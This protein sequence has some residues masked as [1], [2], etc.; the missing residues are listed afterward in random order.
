MWGTL[1]P[2]YLAV[3]VVAALRGWRP[4]L[5][6]LALGG[7]GGF[8]LFIYWPGRFHGHEVRSFVQ[9][10]FYLFIG[11]TIAALAEWGRRQRDDALRRFEEHD[12]RLKLFDLASVLMLDLDHRILRWTAGCQRLYGYT[13]EQAIGRVTP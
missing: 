7:L 1:F 8:V 5:L 11:G 2:F 4:G 12:A 10:G 6:A 13:A 9:L 3:A